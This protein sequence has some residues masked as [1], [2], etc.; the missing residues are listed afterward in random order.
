MENKRPGLWP[1]MLTPFTKEGEI[2]YDGLKRLIDW[3]VTQ[4]A[5]GLFA[6]CQS[7][8]MFF[9]S[10]RERVELASFVKRHAPVTVIA[11]GHVSWSPSDQAEELRRIAETGGDAIVLI[12]NRMADEGEDSTVW[13]RRTEALMNALPEETPL[14]LYECPYL[15]KRLVSP[16]ELRFCAGS[17]RFQFLKDTCCDMNTIR[18]RLSILEGSPLEL[19]NANTATLLESLRCGAAGFSGVMANIHPQLY[20]WLLRH[21][22]SEPERA[23]RLQA[24]LTYASMM[25]GRL[26]PVNA[27]QYLRGEGLP[28]TNR[29]RSGNALAATELHRKEIAQLRTMTA[30]MEQITCEQGCVQ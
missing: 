8:E 18:E 25:E 6:V 26:Y 17:G 22:D 3:Y 20:D 14:G 23:E 10:L 9:L 1:V 27:K 2:D 13:L 5:T 29:C 24:G 28:I 30:W 7:S 12:T 16:E 19:Y 4:G 15:Y 11:S 21:Y